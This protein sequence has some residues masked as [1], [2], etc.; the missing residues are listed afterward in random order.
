MRKRRARTGRNDRWER[1]TLAALIPES[2]LQD[3]GHLRFAKTRFDLS[4]RRLECAGGDPA[5]LADEGDFLRILSLA[6]SFDEIERGAPLPPGSVFQKALKIAVEQMG[7][8]EAR[9]GYSGKIRQILPETR[10]QALRLDHDARDVGHLIAH[11]GL[12][13][14]IRDEDRVALRHK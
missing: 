4:K 13:P 3:P 10:P 11:L 1:E 7:R 9:H 8:F 14:E 5:R 2:F 6:E 12:V